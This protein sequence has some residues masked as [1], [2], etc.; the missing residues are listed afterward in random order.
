MDT[1]CAAVLVWAAQTGSLS[2]ASRRLGITPMVATRR[3][4]A[5]ERDLGVRLMHK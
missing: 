2:A 3:L 4:A 1:E 5:L